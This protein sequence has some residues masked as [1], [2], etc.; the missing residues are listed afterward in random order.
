MQT[1][2]RASCHLSILSS[3]SIYFAAPATVPVYTNCFFFP[4]PPVFCSALLYVVA[5]TTREGTMG[6]LNSTSPFV[7]RLSRLLLSVF[8]YGTITAQFIPSIKTVLAALCT[9]SFFSGICATLSLSLSLCLCSDLCI[10]G[11]TD[12][13]KMLHQP[14]VI[15]AN[16]DLSNV[17]ATTFLNKTTCLYSPCTPVGHKEKIKPVSGRADTGATL[18]CGETDIGILT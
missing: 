3:G 9:I 7:L 8:I 10:P 5:A 1:S 13:N 2:R 4:S 18:P 14:S 16:C 12:R 6:P 17:H 11:R 15:H